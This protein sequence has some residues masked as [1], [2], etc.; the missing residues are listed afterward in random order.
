MEPQFRRGFIS[1]LETIMSRVFPR[2]VAEGTRKNS[3]N[4]PWSR[5]LHFTF[6]EA[7]S[8][9]SSLFPIQ[10]NETG[11]YRKDAKIEVSTTCC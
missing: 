6:F 7:S 2:S 1:R 10:F 3:I 8:C 4:L 9:F 5:G 11:C